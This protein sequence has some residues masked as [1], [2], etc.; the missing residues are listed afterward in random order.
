MSIIYLHLI[1]KQRQGH[2]FV[3]LIFLVSHFLWRRLLSRVAVFNV[4]NNPIVAEIP[5]TTKGTFER[6]EAQMMYVCMFVKVS[7]V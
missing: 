3:I 2:N 1:L 7:F 6:L 5:V 4:F